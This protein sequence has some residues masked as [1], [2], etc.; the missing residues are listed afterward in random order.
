MT[1]K[2]V[3]GLLAGL[4][5]AALGLGF[6]QAQDANM[7]VLQ[8]PAII[9]TAIADD[10]QPS[11]AIPVGPRIYPEG[12]NPL[13]G[14]P[15]PDDE[16][17][18]RRNLIVKVS[19]WPPRVRP[20]RG[21][22]SADIVYEYEAEGGV[23]RFA[24]IYRSQSP[25]QVGSIRSARLLD[26]ELIRMYHALLAY[27]GT[28]APLRPLYLDSD[29]RN[30]LISP[31]LGHDCERAG[32]C[33]DNAYIERGY[34]HTLFANTDKLWGYAARINVNHGYRALGMHFGLQAAAGGA[35]AQDVYMNWYNRTDARWQHDK[36]TGS[37]LRYADGAPHLD[38]TDNSQLRADNLI[39]LQVRHISRPDLFAPG[40]RDES[41][42]VAL[43]GTGKAMVLRDGLRY[44]G[45]WQRTGARSGDAL[46]LNHNDG[47]PIALKPGRSWITVMRNLES[48]DISETRQPL[49]S[50]V[51]ADS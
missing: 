21:I 25:G 45:Y 24:A 33:R 27:S 14:L 39:F 43:Y 37:Y 26:I 47:M 8:A 11:F 42:E 18:N 17:R 15:Y 36:D 19:N 34:E 13:T 49:D 35:P 3:P 10:Y 32:F 23:T 2:A 46:E 4:L 38:T 50:I 16:A 7:P 22:N 6:A 44:D 20:Q 51:R 12:I 5:L 28:S 9:A 29:F 30:Q 31:S 40:A 48:L 41:Q 1:R